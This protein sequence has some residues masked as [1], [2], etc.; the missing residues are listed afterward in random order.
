[1][2]IPTRN[3]TKHSYSPATRLPFTRIGAARDASWRPKA[4]S[5]YSICIR[6]AFEILSGVY[7]RINFK[8]AASRKVREMRTPPMGSGLPCDIQERFG[9]GRVRQRFFFLFFSKGLLTHCV[10]LRLCFS[11]SFLPFFSLAWLLTQTSGFAP[12]RDNER[13]RYPF[14]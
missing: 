5:S 8:F 9:I 13:S 7:C 2:C 11:F 3:F 14:F 12:C 1:M 10:H 6:S 4:S